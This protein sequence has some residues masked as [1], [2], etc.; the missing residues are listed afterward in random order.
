MLA[1]KRQARAAMCEGVLHTAAHQPVDALLHIGW[2]RAADR[3]PAE[4]NRRTGGP[5]PELA[6]VEDLLQ[7]LCR[8]GESILVNDHARIELAG[9]ERRLDCRKH[10]RRLALSVRKREPKQQVCCRVRS[11]DCDADRSRRDVFLRDRP[12]RDEQRTAIPAERAA[13]VQQDVAGGAV[14]VRVI[15]ELRDV[16]GPIE[17]RAVE[18]FNVVEAYRQLEIFEI[19]ASV[20]DRVEHEAVVRAGREPEGQ[21]HAASSTSV[22]TRQRRATASSTFQAPRFRRSTTFETERTCANGTLWIRQAYMKPAPS[23]LST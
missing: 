5:L 15:T 13:G 9:E 22:A 7:P 19:D 23:M 3:D 1:D 14:R 6:E 12:L 4:R 21:F 8:V 2:Q 10:D 16:D 11:G 20:D 17:R 18:A